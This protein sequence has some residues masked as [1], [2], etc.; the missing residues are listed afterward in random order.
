MR[1]TSLDLTVVLAYLVLVLVLGIVYAR[2]AGRSEEGFFAADRRLPWWLA[3]VSL[4]ATSFSVDT[5]MG[6]AG[7]VGRD[8][9]AGVWFAWSFAIGGVGMLGYAL[10]AELWRR[11]GVLTDAELVELR[12]SGRPA[13]A[14]RLVKALYFGVLL[15]ALTLAWVLKSVETLSEELLGS[16]ARGGLTV[17]LAVTVAY[18]AGAGLWGVVVTDFAQYGFILAGIV[19][20]AVRALTRVGG[21]EGLG[22]RLAAQLGENEAAARLAFVPAPD[23]PFFPTFL[24]Y[25]LVLW[26]AHKNA[27]AAGP[28][29]Q[30]LVASSDER[31]ARRTALGFTFGMFA[32]NYW[33]MIVIGLAAVALYPGMPAEQGFVRL[34]AAELPP[35]VLGFGLA[36]LAAAFMSTTSSLLNLG[37]SYLEHDVIRRFLRPAASERERVRWARAGTV[38]I[39]GLALAIST[40][41][42]SVA[43]AWGLMASV[44]AGYGLVTVV[45]WFWWRVNAWSEIAALTA[46]AAATASLR[47]LDPPPAAGAEIALVV[48]LS[49]PVWLLVTMLTPPVEEAVLNGFVTRVRPWG[50]WGRHGAAAGLGRRL[51][52]W[53][54]GTAAVLALNFSLGSVIFGRPSQAALLAAAALVSGWLFRRLDAAPRRGPGTAAAGASPGSPGAGC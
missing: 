18:S 50:W 24:S 52:L 11:S 5:P 42:E 34:L 48:A 31:E 16:A 32:M 35:G 9:I 29:V 54:A 37:A 30:R 46:S 45:R 40:R 38:A 44:T 49:T 53:L 4:I 47:G 6:I 12:Y 14:L 51:A 1:L 2:R 26:W 39:L 28:V 36:C 41:L 10:F 13:A 21:V 8:G 19:A 25:L 17:I 33:P 22:E 7:L 15:N 3:S 23:D 43:G 20:L 27:S